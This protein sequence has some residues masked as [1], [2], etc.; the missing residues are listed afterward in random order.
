MKLGLQ[1]YSI[2][3]A[4]GSDFAGTL[5]QVKQMG[6]QG[7]E[8]YGTQLPAEELKALFTEL[9]LELIGHHF[10]FAELRDNFEACAIRAKACGTNNLICAWSMPT[11]NEPWE[12]IIKGLKTISAQAKAAG[13]NFMYHNHDHEI[14]QVVNGQ[15]VMDA[16]LEICNAEIDIAW[17]HAG[18]AD[19]VKYLEQNAKKIGLLHIKDV[20]HEDGKWHTVELGQGSVPLEAC[21]KIAKTTPS[22]WLI[23][24][25]DYSPEPMQSAAK[26]FSWLQAFNSQ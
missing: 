24:E 10:V 6:Y 15:R 26:N 16:I 11:A 7:A 4:L 9:D 21:L 25:Q 3:D 13:L 12:A 20:K 22:P 5:Q 14:S 8:T 23:V 19:V 18:G 1:L 2:R 17:V